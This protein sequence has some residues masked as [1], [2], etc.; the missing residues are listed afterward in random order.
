MTA[1][2]RQQPLADGDPRQVFQAAR[3]HLGLVQPGDVQP[4]SLSRGAGAQTQGA[5]TGKA[6]GL[7]QRIQN[8]LP[9]HDGIDMHRGQVLRDVAQQGQTPLLEQGPDGGIRV[10]GHLV[11]S[12]RA[13]A[14]HA[15]H[16]QRF[17]TRQRATP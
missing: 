12:R 4:H 9:Q 17:L 2:G 5:A 13:G 6:Q 16:P 15:G 11:D 3:P 1:V 7:H 14:R 8:D 10:L